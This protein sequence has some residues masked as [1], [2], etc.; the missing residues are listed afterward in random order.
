MRRLH[1]QLL[2]ARRINQVNGCR[3]CLHTLANNA[4]FSEKRGQSPHDPMGHATHPQG[5]SGTSGDHT[6]IRAADAPEVNAPPHNADD[7]KP[8]KQNQTKF[9]RRVKPHFLLKSYT[10]LFNCLDPIIQLLIVL[11]EHFDHMNIGVAVH[12]TPRHSTARIRRRRRCG[13]DAPHS[14]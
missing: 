9:H 5:Q 10:R 7:Q 4:H 8:I 6:H 13:A 12:H 1:L 14:P 3:D 2:S 11:R